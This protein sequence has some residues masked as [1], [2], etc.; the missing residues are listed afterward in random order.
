[1]HSI[2]MQSKAFDLMLCIEMSNRY[3]KIKI[4]PSSVSTANSINDEGDISKVV[5]LAQ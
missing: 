2:I 5:R 3:C 1:M 4:I